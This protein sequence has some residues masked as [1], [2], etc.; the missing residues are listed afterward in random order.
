MSSRR[1]LGY[2]DLIYED[3]EEIH[4]NALDHAGQS[5][6]EE[7]LRAII[8]TPRREL[9]KNNPIF[10]IRDKK[11]GIIGHA[12]AVR[13]KQK[14][15]GDLY[16]SDSTIELQ[17]LV[18]V[19]KYRGAGEGRKLLREMAEFPKRRRFPHVI[20]QVPQGM[21]G[22]FEESGWDVSATGWAWLEPKPNIARTAPGVPKV[23]L[24]RVGPDIIR[25]KRAVARAVGDPMQGVA[26]PLDAKATD[27]ELFEKIVRRRT[28]EW[29]EA[30][31][32]EA[33]LKLMRAKA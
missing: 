16:E 12:Y 24:L 31:Q 25:G 13:Q 15:N 8:T 14:Y 17:S 18:V 5:L 32:L 30:E 11:A 7:E 1:V 23:R 26:I 9:W 29:A 28:P 2:E 22:L 3:A 10:V 4:D 20:S 33:A 19:T 27:I 21:N 6:V